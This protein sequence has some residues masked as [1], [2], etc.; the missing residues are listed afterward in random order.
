MVWQR[1]MQSDSHNEPFC[2]S[3]SFS[4]SRA[5]YFDPLKPFSCR[6][7]EFGHLLAACTSKQSKIQQLIVRL[8]LASDT[9]RSLDNSKTQYLYFL[10]SRLACAQMT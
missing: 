3:E 1:R 6:I 4:D 2:M 7:V 9:R 10:R 8:K 5:D